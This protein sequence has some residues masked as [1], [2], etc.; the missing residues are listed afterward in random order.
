[1]NIF[2]QNIRLI[3]P[4]Q[5]IDIRTNIWVKSGI[6]HEIGNHE[7]QVDPETEIVECSNYVCSPGLFDMHVHFREP[8]YEYKEDLQSGA[9]SAANGGFTGVLCMPNTDPVVD[10]AQVVHYIN[11]KSIGNLVDI[12]TSAALTVKSEGNHMTPMMELH[13]AGV[14]MFTD[15]GNCVQ[16]SEVMRTI[17]DYAATRDL[18]ISQHCED[19]GLTKNFAMNEGALSDRLGLKGYP[20]IA[21]EIILARD[22]MLSEYCG[23]RRYHAS[24]ISTNGAV[25]IIREAKSRGLRVTAEVTPH[26][27]SLTDAVV[28]NY[29]TN[30]K[31]NPPLRGKR[32][33]DAI[34]EGL[35]D[36]TI[37]VIATDHAP[38]ALHEKDVEFESAPNGIVGLETAL[39][40]S[41]TNLFHTGILSLSELINKLSVNPRRI[42]GLNDILFENGTFANLTV[43]DPN[44]EWVIDKSTFKSRSANTPFHGLRVKGLPKMV[45][46]NSQLFYSKYQ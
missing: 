18:L 39:A 21:E 22:I 37:D 44:Q 38:H 16:S 25:R 9:L 29:D 42:L 19:K 14:L 2:L 36:G 12:H 26:H 3:N 34:L 4:Y 20:Y 41:L 27:F 35:I 5:D 30:S 15:D 8:G 28:E 31:M 43:F 17:F 24:H 6:I 46:N 45:I 40:L 11:Q 32:D 33:V 13:D 7:F 1:M 23:R 10:N